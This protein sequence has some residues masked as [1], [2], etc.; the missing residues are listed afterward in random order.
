MST[1]QSSWPESGQ[2]LRHQHGISVAEAH[3]FLL[4]KHPQRRGAR[5][6]GCIRR[7]GWWKLPLTEANL[8]LIVIHFFP[9]LLP[10]THVLPCCRPSSWPVSILH[11]RIQ[12][13][14][15]DRE[16]KLVWSQGEEWPTESRS[17]CTK[18]NLILTLS[19]LYSRRNKWNV[20]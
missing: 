20:P 2:F 12:N 5:R 6:N 3:T 10:N 4:A 19:A 13:F 15:S 18:W 16:L 14:Q 7:L 17:T 1:N 9:L 11:L 8:Y